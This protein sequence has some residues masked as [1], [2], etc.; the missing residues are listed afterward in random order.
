MSS[1]KPQ[2]KLGLFFA[3]TGHHTASWRHPEAQADAGINF[4]HYV[5]VARKA[6]AAK[7]DMIFLADSVAV[8]E[9]DPDAVSRVAVH[10][11]NIDPLSAVTALAVVTQNIG[12]VSTAST[13]YHEPY[14][15]ARTF[16]SLDHISGGRAGW[17]IVTSTQHAEALNF[18]REGHFSHAERYERAHE[19]TSVMLKLWDSW[20]DDAFLRNKETGVFYDVSKL[21][22]VNHK[23]KFFGVKGPLNVPRPPQGRPVLIQAG[24]SDDGRAFASRFAEVVFTSHLQ[25]S[26]AKKYYDNLKNDLAQVGR[27]ADSVRM[28]PGLIPLVGRSEEDARV[29]FEF[30]EGLTDIVVARDFLSMLL[31][32]NLSS[33]PLDEPVPDL[34][35]PAQASG[36]FHHWI[37]LARREDLTLRQLALRAARG[38]VNV[39]CGSYMQVADY[40]EDW[41]AQGACDGFNIMPPYIPGAF[42]DFVELVIPELQRRRVFRTEYE[43]KTL[44]DNLGLKRPESIYGAASA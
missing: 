20:D 23:G 15:L 21:H 5:D 4:A 8:R 42:D 37:D 22:P 6:E 29:K 26:D 39:I 7:M 24:V 19:F 27:G 10:V 12:L 9:G 35:P 44:R 40:I 1:R 31:R 43:G 16:A 17:N 30:L 36:S 3:P 28:M 34:E 14:H 2:V 38:R 11:A 41:V 13:S 25:A 18:G 32:T 33:Y